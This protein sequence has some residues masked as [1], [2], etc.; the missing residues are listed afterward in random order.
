[1]SFTIVR[2]SARN[3][4]N[5]NYLY[6]NYLTSLEPNNNPLEPVTLEV[7]IMKGL[8]QVHLYS[9]L[10]KTVNELIEK[11]LVYISQNKVQNIHYSLPFNTIALVHRLKSFKNCG[12]KNFFDKAIDIFAAMNDTDISQIDETV[13]S[14]SLQNIWTNTII[15]VT[16]C[17]GINDFNIP[18]QVRTTIDEL[19]EKRNAVAHGRETAS[20]VGE[21]FR[22]DVMRKKMNTIANFAY[23]LI[24]TFEEYY[25]NKDF[26]KSEAKF[27][28]EAPILNAD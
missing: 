1:M 24:D 27:Q 23:E 5:E 6:L 7:K 2:N 14:T 8:F 16:K 19:V 12:Y 22:V 17:F 13:F 11:T 10:E 9:S 3:R 18:A 21:R 4:F 28:Y 20:V 15:E 26:L 25:T